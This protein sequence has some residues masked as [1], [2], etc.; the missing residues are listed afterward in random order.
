MSIL[1][2][3][4]GGEAEASGRPGA[5]GTGAGVDALAEL[6]RV[7][8]NLAALALVVEEIRSRLNGHT[9]LGAAPALPAAERAHT[10][11]EM[12]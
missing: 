11:Y 4:T 2:A 12:H 1:Q 9:H 6:E 8:S 10:P 7:R 5:A 3:N